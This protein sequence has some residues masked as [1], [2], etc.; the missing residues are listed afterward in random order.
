MKIS[1]RSL[2]KL[3]ASTG[4]VAMAPTLLLPKRA[5]AATTGAFGAVRHVLVLH[6][7]GGFRS[8]CT[9]NAVGAFQHNPFGTQAT[10]AGTEWALGGAC[11]SLTYDT[12]LGTVPKLGDVSTDIAVLACVDQNPG[13]EAEIDHVKGHRRAAT[14]QEQGDTGI[15]SIVGAHHALYQNGFTSTVMPPVEIVPTDM[16]LGAGSYGDRR[17]L[18][19][20]GAQQGVSG[21]LTI[22]DGFHTELRKTLDEEF[23]ARRSRAYSQRL[24]NFR[25][26]K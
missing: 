8:H 23:L 4:A 9:F 15:L 12:S 24:R 19:L 26:A 7:Q 16:G 22:K 18:S 6:A 20:L 21:G 25:I 3:A 11:G 1:R 17:P 2:L 5:R 14:G 13:G 10:A